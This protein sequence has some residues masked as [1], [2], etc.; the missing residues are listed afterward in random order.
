MTNAR[1]ASPTAACFAVA[2]LRIALIR[3]SHRTADR[4]SRQRT[5]RT[6]VLAP[7]ASAI[8]RNLAPGQEVQQQLVELI[9]RVE[10][11]EV[12]DSLQAFVA[13]RPADPRC[14]LDHRVLS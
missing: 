8:P 1:P 6:T 9:R 12:A 13:P 10:G 11:N 7:K 3:S 2:S 14:G 4:Q 5:M